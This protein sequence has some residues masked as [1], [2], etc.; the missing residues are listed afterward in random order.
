MNLLNEVRF[1]EQAFAIH[2]C[3]ITSYYLVHG[4]SSIML[5][6]AQKINS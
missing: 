1:V 3:Y 5:T 6:T 2:I 4:Y